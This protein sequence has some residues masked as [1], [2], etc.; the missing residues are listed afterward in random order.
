[1]LFN[2]YDYPKSAVVKYITGKVF[3]RGPF[4]LYNFKLEDTL[5]TLFY[6]GLLTLEGDEHKHQVG[7]F[8]FQDLFANRCLILLHVAQDFGQL[9]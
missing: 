6:I 1:V 8:L 4:L 5:M 9:C 3:G 7:F 2:L